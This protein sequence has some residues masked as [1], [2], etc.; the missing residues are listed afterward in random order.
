MSGGLFTKA[1]AREVSAQGIRVNAIA[2]GPFVTNIGDGWVKKNPAAKAA[3]D[4]LVPVGRM[5]FTNYLTQTLI[6]TTLFYMPWG[7]HWFATVPPAATASAGVETRALCDFDAVLKKFLAAG[8]SV[9][10]PLTNARPG[11][12][13][14]H[15]CRDPFG[16][17]LC[18]VEVGTEFTG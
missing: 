10:K 5:A 15:Y 13:K 3:W 6:M 14:I 18:F 4:Q 12:A 7:L 2:P 16:N 11:G 8:G 1:L 17:P 9:I